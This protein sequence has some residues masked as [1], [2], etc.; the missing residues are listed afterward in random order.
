MFRKLVTTILPK[1][2]FRPDPNTSKSAAEDNIPCI[3]KT[4]LDVRFVGSIRYKL[5]IYPIVKIQDNYN[6][7]I[8]IR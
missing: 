8:D 6:Y 3:A 1:A 5:S 4:T 2:L 7:S